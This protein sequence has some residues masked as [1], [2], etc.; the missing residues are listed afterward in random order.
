MKYLLLVY[1]FSQLL[2]KNEAIE[3]KTEALEKLVEKSK[4]MGGFSDRERCYETPSCEIDGPRNINSSHFSA[5]DGA[6]RGTIRGTF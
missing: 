3:L 4:F 6:N 5:N 1:F 2:F